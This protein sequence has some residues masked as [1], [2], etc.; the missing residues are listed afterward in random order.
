MSAGLI[1]L[2]GNDIL[3][4]IEGVEKE[5]RFAVGE[6]RPKLEVWAQ[7]YD[8]AVRV[9][10]EGELASI[11]REMF[12]WLDG[13]GWASEWA[14]RVGDDR[15]LE[16]KVKGNGAPEEIALLDAPWEV[17]SFGKTGPLAL[18]ELQL[19][20]VVR[21]VG[22]K[23]TPWPA[24]NGDL[25]LMFVAAAP[26]GAGELDFE[27]EEAAIL[28][29]TQGLPLRLV[30]EESGALNFVHERLVSDEASFEALHLSCHG[31]IDAKA[32]P[33]LLLETPE[34][35]EGKAGPREIIEA[36]GTDPPP[37]IVLSACRTARIRARASSYWTARY[38]RE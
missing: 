31:T 28:K 18:D 37:L 35:Y 17:L 3:C 13:S 34:G 15:Q 24:R 22:D 21:R 1:E 4:S 33:I 29:A 2:I 12:A 14:N 10:N 32:G 27:A 7:R 16:I 19:F 20:I 11:G 9:D 5:A 6:A 23:A 38:S 36:L 8:E 25:Q 26:E 30:V